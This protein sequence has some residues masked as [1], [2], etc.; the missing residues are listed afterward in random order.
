MPEKIP[1]TAPSAGPMKNA[2]MIDAL[3]SM[4]MRPAASRSCDVARIALPM[5]VRETNWSSAT[6]RVIA[7]TTMTT[8]STLTETL[9]DGEG[10]GVAEGVGKRDLLRVDPQQNRVLQEDRHADRRDQRGETRGVPQRA[11]GEAL[12][13]HAH[14]ADDDGR[15]RN[16]MASIA[17]SPAVPP[18]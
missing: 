3:M 14:D 10:H 13:Q 4:P 1:A 12:D 7:V 2:S 11:V 17:I 6:M 9:A 8:F 5:R 15:T 16:T 18:W